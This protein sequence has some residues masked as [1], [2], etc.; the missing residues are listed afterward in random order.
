MEQ[1]DYVFEW[2]MKNPL[3][4]TRKKHTFVYQDNVCFFQRNKSLAGFVK[5]TSCVKYASRVKCAAAR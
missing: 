4:A 5:C 3:P 2:A 1:D